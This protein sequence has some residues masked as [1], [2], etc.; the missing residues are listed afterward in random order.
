MCFRPYVAAFACLHSLRG[1]HVVVSKL[2]TEEEKSKVL[3]ITDRRQMQK[4]TELILF[5]SS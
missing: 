3:K 4:F 5:V 2:K 1:G